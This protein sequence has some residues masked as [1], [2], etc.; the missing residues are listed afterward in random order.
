MEE[1]SA[2]PGGAQ[3]D[4]RLADAWV[5]R[6]DLIRYARRLLGGQGESAEDIVQEAFLRLHERRATGASVHEARPW[7]FR[8]TRNLALDERRRTRRGDAARASLEVVATGQ[9]GPHEVLQG[10]EEARQALSGLGALPPRERRTVL[11]E[12]AG[13]APP[14]IARLMHTTTNAVHQS[15]FRARRRLRET[16]AAAWGLV[17]VPVVRLLLRAAGGL[18]LDRLPPLAPGSGGRLA[19]GAGAAGVV[20]AALLGGGVVAEQPSPPPPHHQRQV[21]SPPATRLPAG[22]ASGPATPRVVV[23]VAPQRSRPREDGGGGEDGGAR[24]ERATHEASASGE[25]RPRA[26]IGDDRAAAATHDDGPRDPVQAEQPSTEHAV[27]VET[28]VGI[29]HAKSVEDA[30]PGTSETTPSPAAAERDSDR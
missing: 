11:L 22:Q 18:E 25:S 13:V 30:A 23:V 29:R 10:R 15:L 16:R 12:Q 26:E 28:E 1:T 24:D 2:G 8:V 6:E 14:T 19:G 3:P 7:L 17:P 5:H 20:A 21:A 9:P 4:P 27:V